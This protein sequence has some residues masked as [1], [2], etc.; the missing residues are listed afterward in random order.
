MIIFLS[1]LLHSQTWINTFWKKKKVIEE[2]EIILA[3]YK[4]IMVPEMI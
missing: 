3:R 1:F 4:A 2:Q